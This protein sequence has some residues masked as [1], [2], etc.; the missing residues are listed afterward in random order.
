MPFQPERFASQIQET[1]NI[2]VDT[3]HRLW[4]YND[5]TG[6]YQQ[7]EADWEVHRWTATLMADPGINSDWKTASAI[8]LPDQGDKVIRV[9]QRRIPR[10]IPG[11]A[12]FAVQTHSQVRSHDPSDPNPKVAHGKYLLACANT[13]LD[14][15]DPSRPQNLGHSPNYYLTAG[16]PHEH[17]PSAEAPT[18]NRFLTETLP[19]QEDRRLLAQFAGACLIDRIPPKGVL[20]LWGP[21]DS[22]KS[23]ICRTLTHL[24][25][26]QNVSA[27]SPHDLSDNRFSAADLFGK[28]ANIVPDI[29]TEPIRNTSLYKQVTGGDLIRADIKFAPAVYFTSTATT[30]Y[31][32]NEL[33]K[34]FNDPTDGFYNR[35]ISIHCPNKVNKPDPHLEPTLQLEAPGILNWAL[36]GLADIH[37]QGWLYTLPPGVIQRQQADYEEANHHIGWINERTLEQTGE[38]LTRKDAYQDYATWAERQGHKP[39]G[40]SRFFT[41]LRDTWGTDRKTKGVFGWDN[42]GLYI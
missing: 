20:Y 3:A 19:D 28:M 12:Q 8:P 29:A 22:G 14:L 37:E 24:L 27:V 41:R 39:W 31:S 38:F 2:E 42:H 21:A 4:K 32:G 11:D 25:G 6:Y 35:Q 7:A 16:I 17:D 30:L 13:T 40:R 36:T 34:S 5:Q 18:W 10:I 1:L 33:P 9:L 23:T 15:A 26:R